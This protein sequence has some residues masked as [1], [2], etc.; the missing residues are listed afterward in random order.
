MLEKSIVEK[1]LLEAV[2][3][4]GDFAQLFEEK[5]EKSAIKCMDG[6]VDSSTQGFDRGVGLRICH[7]TDSYYGYTSDLSEESLLQLAREL[8]SSIHDEVKINQIKL[9]EIVV[10]P[11]YEVKIPFSQ[12]ALKQKVALMKKANEAALGYNALIKKTI[13]QYMD[14]TQEVW[15][16]DTD[17]RY[18]SDK[19]TR[20][21]F[22]VTAI[23]IDE[24]GKMQDGSMS[25]G[26]SYGFEFYDSIDVE[27][28]AKQA[29]KTAVT[30]LFADPCPSGVMPVVIDHGFGGVI[31]HEACG[32]SLEATSV[33]KN[34]SV[35]S[36]KLG[37][38]IASDV[39]TA[40]D[41]ATIPNA[42]GSASIDDDGYPTKR[43]VL[44]ENGVLKS[45]MIDSFN[46]RRMKMEHTSS[47]RRQSYKFEPTSRMSNTFIANGSSTFEEI[48]QV[49]K[50]GLYAKRLGG[51]SVDPS[52]GDF[53][54]AV[55]EA[56]LI[57]DGKITKPVSGATII[58][59]GSDTLLK[60]DMVAN[61][62]ERE[63]GM[64]GSIS[65]SIC[66]DVGQPTIR[67]MDMTV[68]G[69]EHE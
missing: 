56:Y 48:I 31:F 33:A 50:K 30:M 44:I 39:V 66:A 54:F 55:L 10:Q 32:H 7:G 67:V 18:V 2:Q 19:R 49:T 11:L 17:G 40:I 41:D 47:S 59:N 22:Y 24:H 37:Q 52:T 28:L 45:Y 42:W 5:T 43:N 57:E 20:T 14:Q 58:G 61:N 6:R 35:F 15:I 12:V 27:E 53:N 34:Q 4:G 29:S 13:V 16:A 38:K 9:G 25:K 26:G 69:S 62:C 36:G 60:I 8:R 1:V 63:Q 21:R 65:G 51:G 46:Q 68:G 64:C 23:A 3:T